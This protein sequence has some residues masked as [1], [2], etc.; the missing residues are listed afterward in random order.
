M[1]TN[2][3]ELY[4]DLDSY[5]T[6]R[7]GGFSLFKRKKKGEKE[8]IAEVAPNDSIPK[9]K[10]DEVIKY[11]K[12]TAQV[13]PSEDPR[14]EIIYEEKGRPSARAS[15][16]EETLEEVKKG[17]EEKRRSLKTFFLGLF[18]KKHSAMAEMQQ[19]YEAKEQLYK[20]D[21]K[22]LAKFTHGILKELPPQMRREFIESEQ[23]L[24]YKEILERNNFV[25]KP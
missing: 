12:I 14:I 1:D 10:V 25:S 9:N 22:I 24:Q 3:D 17:E 11:N 13:L 7:Q 2:R 15:E 16:F 4:K 19:E 8:K 20:D 18:N 23:F 21:L 6:E 5:L